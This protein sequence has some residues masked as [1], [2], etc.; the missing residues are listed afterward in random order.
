[1]DQEYQATNEIPEVKQ[2]DHVSPEVIMNQAPQHEKT[3]QSMRAWLLGFGDLK[4][5]TSVSMRFTVGEAEYPTKGPHSLIP[6]LTRWLRLWFEKSLDESQDRQHL[7]WLLR[8][9]ADYIDLDHW[10]LNHEEVLGL[11]QTLHYICTNA[12]QQNQIEGCLGVYEAVAET[13]SFPLECLPNV[14]G[15]LCSAIIILEN[16]SPKSTN[17]I[18]LL[19]SGALSRDTVTTLVAQLLVVKQTNEFRQ[20]EKS[21]QEDLIRASIYAR[22]AARHLATLIEVVNAGEKF[23][24][25]LVELFT[26]LQQ[27]AESRLLRLAT[28]ILHL[29]SEILHSPR[30]DEIASDREVIHSLI[31]IYD[32]SEAASIVPDVAQ[33][34]N[35]KQQA[36]REELLKRE[37]RYR[38]DHACALAS[39]Q[40]EFA[41]LLPVMDDDQAAD[42]WARIRR[43]DSSMLSTMNMAATSREKMIDYAEQKRICIPGKNDHW[44]EELDYLLRN[45]VINPT[46]RTDAQLEGDTAKPN[47]IQAIRSSIV[48]EGE[49]LRIQQRVRTLRLCVEGIIQAAI[50]AQE[51]PQNLLKGKE[52]LKQLLHG[53]FPHEHNNEVRR[54]FFDELI[55]LCCECRTESGAHP[56][57]DYIIQALQEKI[58]KRAPSDNT[59]DGTYFAGAEAIR[60]IFLQAIALNSN[61]ASQ[62]Y[63]ALLSIASLEC[64]SRRSRLAAM[65][66]LFRIRCDTS[67][68]VYVQQAADSAYLA[69]AVC[70]TDESLAAMFA[71]A[72]DDPATNEHAIT[73]LQEA[74]HKQLWIYPKEAT[75]V[76]SWNSP[77]LSAT[78]I[79]SSVHSKP[80][81][82]LQMSDWLY[83]ITTNLQEDKDW[84]TYSY[85][86]VHLSNQLRDIKLFEGCHQLI[87]V[88]RSFLCG[89]VRDFEKMFD[90]PQD[91]GLRKVDVALCF[92]DI[93][94]HLIPYSKLQQNHG[95]VGHFGNDLVRAFRF[96]VLGKYE[97]TARGCI[98][99]L[100]LCCFETPTAIASEYPGIVYDMS[101]TIHR[102]YLLVHIL[103]FLA[104]VARL[105]QLHSNFNKNEIRQIFGICVNALKTLED[106][107]EHKGNTTT[108]PPRSSTPA[109]ESGALKKCTPYRAVMLQEKGIP[110]YS[111]AL[112]YNTMIF[113]FLSI[114]IIDRRTYV[115]EITSLLVRQDP[116]GQ[117]KVP[118]QMQVFIDMMQRS[119]FSDLQETARNEKLSGDDVNTA[120]YIDG[121]SVITIDT[122]RITG[123]SQITK[124]Q[125]SGTTNAEY[126]PLIQDHPDHYDLSFLE[127]RESDDRVLPSHTLLNMRG[128]AVPLQLSDQP[129]KLNLSEDYVR[130]AITAIDRIPAVDSHGVGVLLAKHGQ[131]SQE[132]Y[133]ANDTGTQSFDDF[134]KLLGTRVSL[135]KPCRFEPHQMEYE[136]DGKETIAWRDR[137]NEI[138]YKIST[139]MPTVDG[140]VYQ[141]QKMGLIGNC[142]VVIVFNQS[143][144]PWKMA[145]Y[146]SEVVS[147]H[148]VISP[149]NRASVQ[150]SSDDID[151][152]FYHLEVLTKEEYQNISAA[153][154]KK[155]VSKATL[156]PLVRMLALNANIFAAT[157]RSL[158]SGQTEFPSSWRARFQ[159]I[160]RLRERTQQR[161]HDNEDSLARRYDF[162]RWT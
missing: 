43:G 55:K 117:T 130:R 63:Q 143:N 65:S 53:M 33:H 34:S 155:V 146:R 110:E 147:V 69:S 105:P 138:V 15:T 94:T 32:L 21:L 75:Y 150:K 19:A 26:A 28:E 90:P 87:V 157:V 92:Y 103:E 160:V 25:D 67:G 156:G 4:P 1:M 66:V 6:L 12:R 27:A 84:E 125:A 128:S 71:D 29:C 38:K 31:E 113:W 60:S 131:I 101:L 161:V 154:E 106:K 50:T 2:G 91:V 140:D 41:L 30:V 36:A 83:R 59:T 118:E 22:G 116:L 112:A 152:E 23:V 102:P 54:A 159:E 142:N 148:I 37:R 3:N 73:R 68:F 89:R 14:L 79:R 153:A 35:T 133:L 49:D 17:C 18:R 42:L 126:Y 52:A 39:L 58:V 47:S 132:E 136:V 70:K 78:Q 86:V 109:R 51:E 80:D 108:H 122:H 119:A 124:R 44:A 5:E 111:A 24:V 82:G 149:A 8:Y 85:I 123:Y 139:F 45:I 97:G 13:D 20:P 48:Q 107:E 64:K 114:P 57:A 98:H 62:A 88:L 137:I 81:E 77:E 145:N 158:A 127:E 11:C 99:A 76:S 121:N 115:N 135:Q 40:D 141:I 144:Q 100:S 93:L 129:L 7:I 9:T 16:P 10:K 162:S 120:S 72:I 96:G 74:L 151:H 134:L 56:Y 104:Q 95:E 61:T 46:D